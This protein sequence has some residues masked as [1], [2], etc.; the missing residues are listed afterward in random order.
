MAKML[1]EK[2]L[3]REQFIAD[4]IVRLRQELK[5]VGVEMPKSTGDPSTSTASGTRC[6]RRMSIFRSL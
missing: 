5:T 4:A 1:D 6:A 2:R 3:E